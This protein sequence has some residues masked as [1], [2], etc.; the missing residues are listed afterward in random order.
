M[1][2]A[3]L[4]PARAQEVKDSPIFFTIRIF[5]LAGKK[6][7]D[8]TDQFFKMSTPASAD[9]A[10]WSRQ[11]GKAYPDARISLLQ[12]AQGRSFQRPAPFVVNI[13]ETSKAHLE[14]HFRTA[15]GLG[16]KDEA[17]INGLI[18]ANFYSGPKTNASLPS[19]IG[20]NNFVTETNKTF[21]FTNRNLMFAPKV[22]AEFVRPG[23]SP[24]LFEN[25][26]HYLLVA[27]SIDSAE[28]PKFSFDFRTSPE[29]QAKALNAPAPEWPE[30]V[31]KSRYTGKALAKVEIK[32]DGSVSAA[33]IWRSS[34]PEANQAIIAA[35][36]KWKFPV[37]AV[38]NASKPIIALLSFEFP[39]KEA[40]P[41]AKP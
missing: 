31:T 40:A 33:S 19:G 14:F 2:L 4:A 3:G 5:E 10:N 37:A 13:G 32:E 21:F 6:G 17:I 20:F 29:L 1:F 38:A 24:S 27:V 9:E 23:N 34:I 11:I 39:K 35:A 22:Y 28:A 7:I 36:L 16:P 8:V 15:L 26:D 18:E 41:E 12:V 25:E 30:I